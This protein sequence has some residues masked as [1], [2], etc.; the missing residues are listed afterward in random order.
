MTT[1]KIALVNLEFLLRHS[2]LFYLFFIV[3][4]IAGCGDSG[5]DSASSLA[6]PP[7]K[8]VAYDV[9]TNSV[10]GTLDHEE[11]SDT[12]DN[13]YTGAPPGCSRN[14]DWLY[15]LFLRSGWWPRLSYLLLL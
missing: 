10:S 5:G 1:K 4:A 13:L 8:P 6:K 7:A 12:A 2:K 11:V 15:L 3:I 9:V 14:G